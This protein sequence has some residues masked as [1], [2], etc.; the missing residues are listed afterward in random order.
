MIARD[1]LSDQTI[2]AYFTRP[3]RSVNHAHILKSGVDDG[4]P[5]FLRPPTVNSRL[6]SRAGLKSMMPLAS[7]PLTTSSW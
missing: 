5:T 2:Q 7:T 4:L 1:D 6:F 3:G